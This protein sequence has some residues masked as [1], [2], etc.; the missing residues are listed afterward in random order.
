M[1]RNYLILLVLLVLIVAGGI[2]F[3]HFESG[4]A[5]RRGGPETAG[6]SRIVSL[7][8]S[9]TETLF[10]LGLGD[11][12][13]GVTRFCRYP[14]QAR[15]KTEVGGYLDPN[16]E[17]IAALEPDLVI[18]LPE[19]ENAISYLRE[20]GLNYLIVHNR[21]VQ[22]IIG[23][24]DLIGS[25]CGAGKRAGELVA[26]IKERKD[27]IARAAAHLASPGVIVSIGR[28][29]GTGALKEVYLAG[30]GTFY[31]E[32]VTL[33]GGENLY[34]DGRVSYPLVSAEGLLH[35]NPE[36]IL[37]LVPD[38]EERGL[39]RETVLQEWQSVPQIDAV[40]NGRVYVLSGDYVSIPGPRIILLLE[41]MAR[42][43]HPEVD[44]DF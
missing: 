29:M 42:A 31:D 19:Y 36:I 6:Y 23:T 9:T 33:A 12:V 4:P 40:R 21:T 2:F 38:L 5:P 1:K 30:K 3:K 15:E 27:R 7:S 34:Q 26:Q 16:Y 22:E 37:E 13:V 28:S 39:S 43:I 14:P 44:W 32:L 17:A 24:I 25:E 8:P 20:L 11:R 35:L 18:I 41:D 10:A